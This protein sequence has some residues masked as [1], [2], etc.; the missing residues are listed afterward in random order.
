M[1]SSMLMSLYAA[2]IDW[3]SGLASAKSRMFW[4]VATASSVKM[5]TL[6]SP[7]PRSWPSTAADVPRYSAR[8]FSQLTS[9]SKSPEPTSLTCTTSWYL[10]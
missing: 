2:A 3:G 1:Y 9:R 10:N 4:K 5:K 7:A 6:N 8:A